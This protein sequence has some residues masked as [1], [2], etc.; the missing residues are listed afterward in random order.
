MKRSIFAF[1]LFLLCASYAHASQQFLQFGLNAYQERKYDLAISNLESAIKSGTQEAL[2]PL[3]YIRM[4]DLPGF[5]KDYKKAAEYV[6]MAKRSGSFNPILYTAYFYQK[7]RTPE[8]AYLV[9][10]AYFA[11]EGGANYK[12][13]SEPAWSWWLKKSKAEGLNNAEQYE[14]LTGE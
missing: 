6:R 14:S 5:P 12:I 9:G 13:G 2:I 4:H 7:T 1:S 8:A 10:L 3:A 11:V